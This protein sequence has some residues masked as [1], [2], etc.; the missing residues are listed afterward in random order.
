MCSVVNVYVVLCNLKKNT[1]SWREGVRRDMIDPGPNLIPLF[2][3]SCADE[4]QDQNVTSF[5]TIKMIKEKSMEVLKRL[6]PSA[7]SLAGVV[8]ASFGWHESVSSSI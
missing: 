8:K 7:R 1:N 5:G 2:A 4:L 3:S 6:P